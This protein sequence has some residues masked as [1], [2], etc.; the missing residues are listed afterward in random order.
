M[1]KTASLFAVYLGRPCFVIAL[2]IILTRT[3][4]VQYRLDNCT[5]QAGHHVH[6]TF[7]HYAFTFFIRTFMY[8]A[9]TL[10]SIRTSAEQYI[11]VTSLNDAFLSTCRLATAVP[12]FSCE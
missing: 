7:M 2:Q 5:V 1:Y 4:H 3:G 12:F 6:N 9:F 10:F 11:P 8:Y